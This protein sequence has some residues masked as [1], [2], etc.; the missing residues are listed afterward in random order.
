MEA[1]KICGMISLELLIIRVLQFR[2][3]LEKKM[4]MILKRQR[5]LNKKYPLNQIWFCFLNGM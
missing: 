5:M 1:I 2:V 3:L 4:F